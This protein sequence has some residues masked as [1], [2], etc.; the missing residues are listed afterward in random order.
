MCHG[1]L[2]M[3]LDKMVDGAVYESHLGLRG[4]SAKGAGT[5]LGN[6]EDGAG[7]GGR[8]A[9]SIWRLLSSSQ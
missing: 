8:G 4:T 5:E 3:V 2:K 1:R 6:Q 9:V 7:E